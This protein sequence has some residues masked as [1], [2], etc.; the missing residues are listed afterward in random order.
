MSEVPEEFGTS[1]ASYGCSSELEFTDFRRGPYALS[2]VSRV[3]GCLRFRPACSQ[4][5][6]RAGFY[7]S[8]NWR[9][10]VLWPTSSLRLW[11]LQLLSLRLRAVRLLR[12][13]MV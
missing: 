13:G 1:P 2:K 4:R 7:R 8:W 3:S 5:R 10:R 11:L 12:P 9:A 6:E